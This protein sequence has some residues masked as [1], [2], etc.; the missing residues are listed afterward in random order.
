MIHTAQVQVVCRLVYTFW[1]PKAAAAAA[2]C[3]SDVRRLTIIITVIIITTIIIRACVPP[4]IGIFHVQ[5]VNT[6]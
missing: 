4:D 2:V 3:A 6:D 1:L 5:R